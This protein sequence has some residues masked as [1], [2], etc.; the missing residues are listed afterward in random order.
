MKLGLIADDTLNANEEYVKLRK[1]YNFIEDP[2][3]FSKLDVIVILGGDG[4]MLHSLRSLRDIN[5]PFYGI[6]AGTL[7]F[8][9]NETSDINIIERINNAKKT[10]IF[11]LCAKVK[12]HQGVV[13]EILAFNEVSLLRET[14]QSAKIEIQIDGLTKVDS[15]IGDG[16]LIA[17]PAGSSAYNFS[18]RGPIIPLGHD[19]LALTPISPF[20]PRGWRGALLPD[21]I[22]VNF[23]IHNSEKRPVSA[24]ADYF[25][26]RDVLEVEVVLD[27]TQSVTLL[28]DHDNP[29]EDKLITEQFL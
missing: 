4:F 22:K 19:L 14:K 2:E 15:L 10:K 7:G 13:K 18:V 26:F 27:K 17:T 5:I 24:V 23:I 28:F 3:Q 9:L 12:N 25:E 16:V 8:L 1:I 11:P 21:N 6:N 29:L 20:R